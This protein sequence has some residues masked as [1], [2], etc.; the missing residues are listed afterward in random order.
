MNIEQLSDNQ[1]VD[2]LLQRDSS[3]T[4]L[5]LY[6]KCRPLFRSIYQRYYTDCADEVELINE[7][8]L[9]I[10]TPGKKTGRSPLEGFTFRCSI[11]LWLK[12]VAEHYCHSLYSHKINTDENIL[13]DSDRNADESLSLVSEDN[14]LTMADASRILD[15]MSNERYRSLIRFRYLEERSNEETAE[16]LGLSMANYY[17]VHLRAKKQWCD[18]LKQEGLL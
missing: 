14:S 11:T 12:I 18:M 13:V 3:V 1:I 6:K 10:M 5:F 16:L 7:I 15:S 2:A 4:R 9:F 8:Y 17:N